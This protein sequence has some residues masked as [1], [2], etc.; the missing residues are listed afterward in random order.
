MAGN[1]CNCIERHRVRK[2]SIVEKVFY[3]SRELCMYFLENEKFEVDGR[4]CIL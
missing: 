1:V 4:L 2:H 3:S